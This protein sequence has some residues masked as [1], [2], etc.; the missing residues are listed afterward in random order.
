MIKQD[1]VIIGAG[2][3]GLMCAATAGY[4]GRSVLVLDHAPKA[5]AKIRISGGGKC[6][7]TNQTVTSEDYLCHNPHFVKSAL[8]RYQPEDFIELVE[9]HGVDYE[10]RD[11]G[12]YFCANRA[13]DLIH[14]LLTEC[15]WA[16]VQLQLKENIVQVVDLK[17]Q[18]PSSNEAYQVDTQTQQIQCQSLVIATGGLSFSKLKA[19]GFG[20]DIAKQFGMP[21]LPKRPGLVPLVMA[22]KL[23]VFCQ[24]LSGLSLEVS[25]TVQMD[26]GTVSVNE[27]MLFTH[28]GFSGP[29]VLKIS[30]YWQAGS[31]LEINLLPQLNLL[32][33]LQNLKAR[34]GNLKTWLNQFWP[35]KFTQ[36]WAEFHTLPEKLAE[37]ANEQLAIL[38]EQISRW[39]IYPA[40]TAGY[41]KAEVTLGG[42]DTSAISSKTMESLKQPNL[43]FIG[44]VL[45]VTGQLGGYNFHWAWASAVAAGQVI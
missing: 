5:A 39:Q 10:V 7:F 22:D 33:E 34:N 11:A 8:A 43:Y 28:F 27:A 30:N 40:K 9:R 37:T 15:D 41:D 26:T 19:S 31:A 2:A 20:Y 6:N 29:A 1:V 4:R 17:A 25:I 16:G 42:V 45:D 21:V 36:A 24:K 32:A 38:A 14:L 18:S 13:G 12:K 23:L 3:A 35:K 44:E